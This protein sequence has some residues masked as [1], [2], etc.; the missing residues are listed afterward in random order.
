MAKNK[1]I[2]VGGGL[3]G[4]MATLKIC[5]AGGIDLYPADSDCI[6]L[7]TE[8]FRRRYYRSGKII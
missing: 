3:S 5:E 6:L 8:C 1:I 7:L 4:L 2:V